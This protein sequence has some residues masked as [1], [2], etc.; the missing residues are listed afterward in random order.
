[1]KHART[2]ATL[3]V[4]TTEHRGVFFGTLASYDEEAKRA[5]LTDAQMCVYWSTDV[6]GVVG[7]AA[8]GPT[9]SCRIT[10]AAPK[11]TLEGVTAIIEAT[12]GA[13]K[14]W[15]ERPWE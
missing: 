5:V 1:M 14:Q 13:A 3:A 9:K 6:H 15:R 8:N 12:E 4:V 2:K 11:M 7:L 10:P